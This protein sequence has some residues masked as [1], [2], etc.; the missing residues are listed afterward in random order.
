VCE[1]ISVRTPE[2]NNPSFGI[3]LRDIEETTEVVFGTFNKVGDKED[4]R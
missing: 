4:I 1:D 3:C 2:G